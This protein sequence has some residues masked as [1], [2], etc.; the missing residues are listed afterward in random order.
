MIPAMYMLT[1]I[2]ACV[3]CQWLQ[4]LAPRALAGASI[5][6]VVFLVTDV[7]RSY[8]SVWASDPRVGLWYDQSVMAEAQRI[9]ALPAAL[10]KYVILD[11]NDGMIR[12]APMGAQ[13]IM[14][15]TDT[16]SESDQHAKNLR[17]LLPDQT[18]QIA[19]GYVYVTY[20]EATRQ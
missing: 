8:F 7:W 12:G 10:P 18:N 11:A 4:T 13:V 2:G 9:N 5:I 1:G 20:I 19:R 16:F 3:I 14:F 6:L 15:L 17:Y